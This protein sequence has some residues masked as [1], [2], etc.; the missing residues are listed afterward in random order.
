MV[1]GSSV[2]TDVNGINNQVFSTLGGTLSLNLE[3]YPNFGYSPMLIILMATTDTKYR[4]GFNK[5]K[6]TIAKLNILH[7][8]MI[9][10]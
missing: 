6:L 10:V 7:W 2:V 4:R 5:L 8:V 9:I 3:F 1:S